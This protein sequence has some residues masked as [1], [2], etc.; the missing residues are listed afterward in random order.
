MNK[1]KFKVGDRV[2]LTDNAASLPV[3]GKTGTIIPDK[4]GTICP[5]Y[6]RYVQFDEPTSDGRTF[7]WAYLE[8][9]E[10]INPQK[11][12][13]IVVTSDGKTTTAT[14][15][16]GKKVLK[17]AMATCSDKDTFSFDEGARVAFERLQ[18][19]EPI[20]KQE[21]RPDLYS[22][23]VVCIGKTGVNVPYTVGKVYRCDNGQ[24][25]T[26][27]DYDFTCY[28]GHFE[29]EK[30]RFR[31]GFLSGEAFLVPLVED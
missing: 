23:K 13:V 10:L 21:K 8:K 7:V 11:H 31:V 15:R 4:P 29:G 1:Q 12:P 18:G 22:G 19:R 26:A 24:R 6:G 20:Q 5:E 3:K 30:N 16:E 9:L 14:M 17:T 27:D 2:R 25:F 28:G